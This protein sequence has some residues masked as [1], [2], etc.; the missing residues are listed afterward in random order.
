MHRLHLPASAIHAALTVVHGE[1]AS[2]LR[3]VLRLKVG[4]SVELFDG[5]GHAWPATIDGFG[6]DDAVLRVG[7][8]EERPFLGVRAT[9]VQGLPKGDKFELVLQKAVELGVTR[10]VP[11]A[12]ERSVVKLD[13]RKAAERVQRWQKIADEAARQCGR[14]DVP[15]VLPV[16]SLTSFV[17]QPPTSGERRLLLD[18]E[19][20]A[21]RLRDELT[22]SSAH[23][24]FV[25][26][27]EG[28]LS[29][30]EVEAARKGGYV[31]VTLG[32]RVL[33]TE[34]VGLAVLS[35]LQHVLGDFG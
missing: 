22:D 7:A 21:R 30:A 15:Q 23:Y 4:E 27:P 31:P 18:E 29:R 25:V 1:R 16:Q 33:R 17:S 24:R 5:E 34:T 6:L 9:L 32:P 3:D 26:G 19:E 2:Y 13:E 20:K 8:R 14:A 10:I 11:A 35:V 28:G 12:C